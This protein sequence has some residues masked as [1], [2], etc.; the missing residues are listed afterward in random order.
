MHFLIIDDEPSVIES[1]SDIIKEKYTNSEITTALT[2]EEMKAKITK[3][4][5]VAFVDIVL[6]EKN[7]T[8]YTAYLKEFCE[9]IIII[10]IS[11]YLE[12]VPDIFCSVSP[13]G[14]IDKPIKNSV[15]YFYIDKIISE[16]YSY[17]EFV[18]DHQKHKINCSEIMYIESEAKKIKIK[19]SDE[20]YVL[21][22][23]LSDIKRQL[24][25]FFIFAHKSFIVNLNHIRELKNEG[26]V[27]KN[28]NFIPISRSRK[29]DAIRSYYLIKG[30]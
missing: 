17:I 18:S 22:G 29:K 12:R 15:V 30:K 24:P 19:C 3:D 4:I 13:Y 14:F 11:G 28:G 6:G 8:E 1:L 26:F 27:M 2:I 7:G 21:V 23:K 10:F 25:N 20:G 16:K 5:D 9:N